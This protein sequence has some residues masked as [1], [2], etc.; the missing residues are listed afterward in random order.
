[1]VPEVIYLFV[2]KGRDYSSDL[3]PGHSLPIT[4]LAPLQGEG[5]SGCLRVWDA[6][7]A[8]CPSGRGHC[9]AMAAALLCL[10]PHFMRLGRALTHLRSCTF[11]VHIGHWVG[12]YIKLGKT[13]RYIFMVRGGRLGILF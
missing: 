1:M 10:L 7:G 4:L 3:I 8:M 11:L 2:Y 12:L 5:A 13:L 9:V 6:H